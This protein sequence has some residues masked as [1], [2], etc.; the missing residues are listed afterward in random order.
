MMPSRYGSSEAGPPSRLPRVTLANDGDRVRG[1][2]VH[3]NQVAGITIEEVLQTLRSTEILGRP[4][5]CPPRKDASFTGVAARPHTTTP[6]CSYR[7]AGIN[8]RR[9][10]RLPILDV[11]H[12]CQDDARGANGRRDE[13]AENTNQSAHQQLNRHGQRWR[14]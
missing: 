7:L 13:Q 2:S 9:R 6:P 11:Q 10:S 4:M 1:A 5:G 8:V 14:K 12:L 3:G